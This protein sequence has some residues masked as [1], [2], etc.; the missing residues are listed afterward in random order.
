[1]PD[2]DYWIA[3]LTPSA[4]AAGRHLAIVEHSEY[5]EIGIS[6]GAL[7]DRIPMP[8]ALQ[9]QL[10]APAS[11]AEQM[12]TYLLMDAGLHSELW[13][14]FDPGE[15]DL[16]CRCLFKGHAAENLKTVAPYLVD[17]TAT[18]ETTRFH[19][20]FFSR[21]WLYETGI[22]IQSDIGMDRMWKHFR[23]F[24]KVNTPEGTVAYFRFWDPRLLPYFL[25][26]CSPSDLDRFFS[27]PNTR[28]WMTTRSR[29]TGMVKVK[30]A[31]LVSL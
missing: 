16:P 2:E 25:R 11:D 23:R 10:F 6:K 3:S 21:D 8:P 27:T 29:L 9:A 7:W 26:A 19:K 13:G 17:L 4:R 1:M 28:I 24:T 18:G 20:E 22:L 15:V 31:S 14:G 30:S 5:A 12:R